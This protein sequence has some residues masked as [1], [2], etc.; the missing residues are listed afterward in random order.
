MAQTLT[1]PRQVSTHEFAPFER[2]S[3]TSDKI[4]SSGGRY[5]DAFIRVVGLFDTEVAS[6]W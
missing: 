1:L 4:E 6:G 5:Q 3:A 2:S